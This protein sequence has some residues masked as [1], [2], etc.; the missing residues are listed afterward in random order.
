M[1]QSEALRIVRYLNTAFPRDAIEHDSA[2]LYATEIA[3]LH[4]GEIGDRA[5]RDCARTLDRFPSIHEFREAYK[6]ISRR[7][8]S[9]R[10]SARHALEP[11]PAPDIRDDIGRMVAATLHRMESPESRDVQ[12][13]GRGECADC[14]HTGNTWTYGTSGRLLCGRCCASRLRARQTTSQEAA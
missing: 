6:S 5:A 7:V 11:G 3:L 13:A 14:G 10:E 1:K 12:D 8:H 2:E 4:D 9:E